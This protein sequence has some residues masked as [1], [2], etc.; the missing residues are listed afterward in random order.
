MPRIEEQSDVLP[1]R[2][3]EMLFFEMV[4]RNPG[5]MH[6][7]TVRD[8]GRISR[9]EFVI[10]PHTVRAINLEQHYTIIDVSSVQ[11][12]LTFEGQA[13]LLSLATIPWA[14]LLR[15][16]RSPR[17]HASAAQMPARLGRRQM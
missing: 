6:A 7:K 1:P 4:P 5:D 15:C 13:F 9:E 16:N 14:D 10:A 17:Q 8:G 2:L 11:P 3:Q 12:S